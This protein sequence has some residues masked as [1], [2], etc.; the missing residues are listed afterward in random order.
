MG[1]WLGREVLALPVWVWAVAGGVTVVWR[2]R[3][4]WVGVDMKVHKIRGE[5][6]G[7]MERMNGNGNGV[8]NG[9][10]RKAIRSR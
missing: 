3:R 2:G 8:V 9:V 5:G 10:G 6:E 1:A 7:E 4:F